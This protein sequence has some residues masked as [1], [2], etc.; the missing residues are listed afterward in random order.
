MFP[1]SCSQLHLYRK[2]LGEGGEIGRA[3]RNEMSITF[4]LMWVG[5]AKYLPIDFHAVRFD[6]VSI[7]TE[8]SGT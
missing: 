5:S 1:P 7:F 8:T 6:F 2:P 3:R 4:M